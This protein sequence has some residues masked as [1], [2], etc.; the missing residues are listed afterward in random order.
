MKQS[1]R[2]LPDVNWGGAGFPTYD[3]QARAADPPAA[4]PPAN[5]PPAAPAPPAPPTDP[6]EMTREQ[7]RQATESQPPAQQAPAQPPAPAAPP[8]QQGG[9][10]AQWPTR[11]QDGT[12]ELRINGS[13]YVG[14]TEQEVMQQVISAHQHAATRITELSGEAE[15]M[16]RAAEAAIGGRP[17]QAGEQGP[18]QWQRE[19]YDELMKQDPGTAMDYY[20]ACRL[21]LSDVNQVPETLQRIYNGATNYELDTTIN[22]FRAQAPDFPFTPDTINKLMDTMK[23]NGVPFSAQNLVMVHRNLVAQ[24]QAAVARG[25]QNP[26]IG[27][28]PATVPQHPGAQQAPMAQAAPQRPANPWEGYN[29]NPQGNYA[30]G[31]NGFGSQPATGYEP[32]RPAAPA[33]PAVAAQPQ[34]LGYDANRQPIYGYPAA[35]AVPAAY[36]AAAPAI[37]GYTAPVPGT[38]GPAVPLA[39]MSPGTGAP[40]MAPGTVDENAIYAMPKEQLREYVMAQ[41]LQR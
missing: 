2:P 19:V 28:A 23:A 12:F 16:R 38:T 7:V 11:L 31:P 15:R 29:P 18:M 20:W 35:P 3:G 1:H 10:P 32:V 40:T 9:A 4:P 8:P 5:Q 27:Y 21:G 17:Q 13:R 25:E 41:G 6:G 22:Q 33:A 14:K 24:Y 34:L 39:T 36:S 30:F 26:Q 37:P